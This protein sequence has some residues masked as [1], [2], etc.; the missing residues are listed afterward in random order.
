M[1]N[2]ILDLLADHQVWRVGD[3][4]KALNAQAANQINFAQLL[5]ALMILTAAGHLASTNSPDEAAQ[6]RQQTD[7]LNAHLIDKA[8]GSADLQYLA[9]PLT[10]GGVQV[11]RFQQLFLLALDQSAEGQRTPQALANF[12]WQILHAQG[13]SIVK[14]GKTL[15]TVEE[16]LAEL[17][18]QAETFLQTQLPLLRTLWVI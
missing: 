2:P 15:L 16:N 14:D 9:S 8:R 12:V 10:G 6:A 4:E 7:K 18:Q 13:Q 17:N 11:G 1:Y 5:Q 3:L